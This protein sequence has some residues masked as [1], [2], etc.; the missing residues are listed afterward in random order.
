V[1]APFADAVTLARGVRDGDW[2]ATELVRGALD[3][4]ARHDG[5]LNCFTYLRPDAALEEAQAVDA[6]RARGEPVGALA[7]VPVAV[8][9]LFDI[10]GVTTLAGSVVLRDAPPAGR[11]ATVLARLR[12]AGAILL[13]ALNMDEFAYGFSTENSHYGDTA[14]PHDPSLI[15]GGSSGGSAAAVAAGF[16]PLSLGSDTNGSIRVPASLCGIYGLK[17][18]FGRLSRAGTYPFVQSL[19]HVGPFARSVRDLA[20]AYDLMQGSDPHDP[21]Q[22]DRMPEP[23]LPAL[24]R[25]APPR[26]VAVLDGWFRRGASPAALAALDRVAG[27]LGATD[28]TELTLAEAARSAAFCLTGSEGGALHLPRL[29]EAAQFYDP[30]VRD[31]LLAG[32]LLPSAVVWQAQRVRSLFREETRRLFERFD[33]LLAPATPFPAVARGHATIMLDGQ[34]VP[35]RANMG[36]YTQPLSFIGLPVVTVPVQDPVAEGEGGLPLGV[37]LIAAPWAEAELLSAAASLEQAGITS[38]RTLPYV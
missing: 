38:V 3:R 21:A 8:K 30:A 7:G 10:G 17:P 36:L 26:R 32:A 4:I 12:A 19:D 31:R 23:S 20:L 25:P 9:N 2:S 35:A 13:G 5:T 15:A 37:Q 1:T 28:T 24:G 33:L 18:T 16:V 29:A 27:A 34:A 22:A 6:A 14:N 11:D